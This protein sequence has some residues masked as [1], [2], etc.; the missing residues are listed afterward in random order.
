MKTRIGSKKLLA[1]VALAA[2]AVTWA[3]WG[4]RPAKAT[5]VVDGNIGPFTVTHN[6]GIRVSAVNTSGDVAII[7]DGDIVGMQG[8]SLMRIFTHRLPPGQGAYLADF[9]PNVADGQLLPVRVH[10]R[11]QSDSSK[12]RESPVL[13]TLEA[14]DTTTGRTFIIDDGKSIIDDGK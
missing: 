1:M 6:V 14:Y 3:V 11:I 5:I 9:V 2:L 4:A 10:V 8:N 12:S 13:I 7:D